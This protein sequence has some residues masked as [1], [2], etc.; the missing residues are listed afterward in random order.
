MLPKPESMPKGRNRFVNTELH[1]ALQCPSLR[2]RLLPGKY[3]ILQIQMQ[4]LLSAL[5]LSLMV[6]RQRS[7]NDYENMNITEQWTLIT[8][9]ARLWDY[10]LKYMHLIHLFFCDCCYVVGAGFWCT[11]RFMHMSTSL[12]S[13]SYVSIRPPHAA[14]AAIDQHLLPSAHSSRS[15]A[16]GLLHLSG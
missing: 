11:G 10:V 1:W 2:R 4:M 8:V 7:R 15:A 9:T 13:T 16:A 14:A 3:R 6:R 12:C 5:S